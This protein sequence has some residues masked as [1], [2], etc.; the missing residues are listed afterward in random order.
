MGP[1]KGLKG[2]IKGLRSKHNAVGSRS[3]RVCCFGFL[4]PAPPQRGGACACDQSYPAR[5][6]VRPAVRRSALPPPSAVSTVLC[7]GVSTRRA[8]FAA[9]GGGVKSRPD[10]PAVTY[11]PS[12]R[13]Q[14][15]TKRKTALAPVAQ[16]LTAQTDA[17]PTTRSACVAL[18][19]TRGGDC[20]ALPHAKAAKCKT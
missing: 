8:I 3:G 18:R 17:A 4:A 5:L 20:A 10:A 16:S 14:T 19:I 13:D 11:C 15:T 7:G 12:L 9:A 1:I 2:P 6:C